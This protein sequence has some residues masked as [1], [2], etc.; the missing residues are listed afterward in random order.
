MAKSKSK[1]GSG[2][3]PAKPASKQPAS[4]VHWRRYGIWA[5][6]IVALVAIV[7]L[8]TRPTAPPAGQASAPTGVVDVGNAEFKAAIAAGDQLI[9]VRTP[10]EYAQGHIPG[11]INIPIDVLPAKVAS[12]DKNKP[13]AVY[14]ATG[15]R[16]LNAKQ[17][18]AA[19]GYKD[20]INLQS[21]I[22]SWDGPTVAG[23]AP[24]DASA[25]TAASGSTG[26][27]SSS[28][29]NGVALVKT[30]GLPVFVEL[31]SPT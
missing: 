23:T 8:V 31:F 22:A 17:F 19:Q 30:T 3:Q 21:G 25:V 26:G 4:A 5:V 10:E 24:G 11:A 13:V 27:G 20:V 16:S 12:I 28:A 14:C 15:S 29:G 1:S 9:D 6:A 7:Y 18:L 2:K